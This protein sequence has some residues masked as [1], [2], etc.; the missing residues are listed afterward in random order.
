MF[1][2]ATTIITFAKNSVKSGIGVGFVKNLNGKLKLEKFWPG[3]ECVPGKNI[4]A[5]SSPLVL[6]SVRPLVLAG[7][8]GTNMES[9]F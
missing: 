1:S 9:S 8:G 3:V 6:P 7:F 2:H 4:N 5:I